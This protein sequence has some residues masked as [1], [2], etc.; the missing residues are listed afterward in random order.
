[1]DKSES[2]REKLAARIKLACGQAG[3]S[4]GQVASLL[5]LHRPAISEIEAGRR[6]VS[7]EELSR[8]A[9]IFDVDLRW[10]AGEEPKSPKSDDKTL[11]A[12]RELAKLKAQDI[13]KVLKLLQTLR[14]KLT[15]SPKTEPGDV[16]ESNQPDGLERILYEEATQCGADRSVL[17]S[18]RRV[19]G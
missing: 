10:L 18:S 15:P 7:S 14:K 11:L 19:F 8:L 4:Q 5:N 13:D 17:T 6:K 3:L 9:E 2:D 12:A 1:M 16:R